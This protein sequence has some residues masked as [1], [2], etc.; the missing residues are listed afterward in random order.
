MGENAGK[1]KKGNPGGPGRPPRETELSYLKK[2][3]E[4]CTLEDW[5]EIVAKALQDAK[6]GDAAARSWIA[7]YL[8]GKPENKAVPL[9][10]IESRERTMQ[11]GHELANMMR[12]AV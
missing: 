3:S 8:V 11:I 4:L 7:A 12:K 2:L 5:G 10:K 6:S 1:F 9:S